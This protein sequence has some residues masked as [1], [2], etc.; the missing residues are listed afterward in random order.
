MALGGC[1]YCR[2]HSFTSSSSSR[3]VDSASSRPCVVST[4]CARFHS[5][6]DRLPPPHITISQSQR[7]QS[8]VQQDAP[9]VYFILS[10]EG[11]LETY[12][13]ALDL[14]RRTLSGS[15]ALT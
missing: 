15:Q 1:T 9:S 10:T 12:N 8:P 3:A 7:P 4:P 2:S 5:R 11:R 14:S 6:H 13:T